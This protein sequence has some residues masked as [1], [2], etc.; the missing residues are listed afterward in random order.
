MFTMRPYLSFLS[1]IKCVSTSD[2][3]EVNFTIIEQG[4]INII[5]IQWGNIALPKSPGS[6]IMKLS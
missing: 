3:W 2:P 5:T 4:I 1:E 6:G